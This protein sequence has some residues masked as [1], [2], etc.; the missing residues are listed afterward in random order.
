MGH[1]DQHIAAAKSVIGRL[2]VG[3]WSVGGRLVVGWWSI[4]QRSVDGAHN[5]GNQMPSRHIM[6]YMGQVG[7]PVALAPRCFYG[8][9]RG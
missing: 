2:V 6:K 8:S 3:W 4:G 9:G 7:S 5:L 1:T